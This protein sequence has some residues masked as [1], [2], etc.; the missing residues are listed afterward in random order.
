MNSEPMLP[1]SASPVAMP[2][3]RSHS[4]GMLRTPSSSGRSLRKVGN[5][6]YHVD[7]GEACRRRLIGRLHERRSPVGHDRVADILV[8]DAAVIADRFGHGRQIAVHHLDE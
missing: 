2:I 4:N 8:D 3:L 7:R 6:I 1:T 5:A